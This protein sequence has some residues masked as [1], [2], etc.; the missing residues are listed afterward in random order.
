[1]NIPE[2]ERDAFYA[3][4][5]E[6]IAEVARRLETVPSLAIDTE[7]DSFYRYHEKVCLVQITGGG[8]DYIIDPLLGG[9]IEPLREVLTRPGVQKLFHSAEN[10]LVLMERSFGFRPA[11][12]LFD[13]FIAAQISGE[14]QVGLSALALKHLGIH[15]DKRFQK[16]DWAE[17]PLLPEHLHYARG[18]THFLHRLQE[19]LWAQVVERGREAHALEEFEVAQAR[20]FERSPFD[21][22]ECLKIQGARDLSPEGLRVL[23]AV[24]EERERLASRVDLPPFRVVSNEALL[25]MAQKLPRTG[26]DLA[27]IKGVSDRIIRRW[28]DQFLGAISYGLTQ[29]APLPKPPPRTPRPRDYEQIE[30]RFQRLR[31]WRE[32]R[33]AELTLPPGIVASNAVLQGLARIAPKDVETLQT[34]PGLRRWQQAEFGEQWLAILQSS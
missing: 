23:M 25:V 9:G 3:S 19:I 32:K 15:L 21:P 14:P 17:R 4:T 34:V 13:T 33:C 16:H 10:D 12:P 30:A 1:M 31:G 11:G 20:N 27:R 22:N 26:S 8:E 28:S 6:E 5:P 2:F 7:S 18:D 24:Y 29:D